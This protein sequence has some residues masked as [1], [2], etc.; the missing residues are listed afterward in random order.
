MSAFAARKYVHGASHAKVRA[1]G[2]L[3]VNGVRYEHGAVVEIAKLGIDANLTAR[4]WST[5]QLDSLSDADLEAL[6]A[7]KSK[8]K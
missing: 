1:P 8:K 3:L 4:L 5:Y 7:P 6:T 2:G